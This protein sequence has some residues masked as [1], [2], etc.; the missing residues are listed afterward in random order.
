MVNPNPGE[1]FEAYGLTWVPLERW[2]NIDEWVTATGGR[3]LKLKLM[4]F[5]G[6]VTWLAEGEA[7]GTADAAIAWA[8]RTCPAAKCGA[9]EHLRNE[10][11]E[12]PE[13]LKCELAAVPLNGFCHRWRAKGDE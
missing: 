6:G 8:I 5:T 4:T 1:P 10:P 11:D 2:L 7:F 9:C 13:C 3:R 12:R